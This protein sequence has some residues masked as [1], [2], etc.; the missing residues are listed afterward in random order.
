[1]KVRRQCASDGKTVVFTNGCFDIIHPGHLHYLTRARKLGDLLVVGVNTDSSVRRIKNSDR[2]VVQE[3]WR[4]VLVDGL[5]PVDYVILFEEETPENL[6]MKIRPDVL[7]KGADYNLEDI[8]GADFVR[9]Y[10][11]KVK[12]I[13]LLSGIS[14][15]MII[16]K[17][18]RLHRS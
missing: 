15:T 4:A 6:I 8:I 12:R 9:R 13:R 10:G 11:G 7:V 2:P 14:S 1:M 17:I 18:V 5:K 16:E 3:K